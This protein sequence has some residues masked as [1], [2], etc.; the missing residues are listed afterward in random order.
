VSKDQQPLTLMFSN[1]V[2]T[3]VRPITYTVDIA[4][5]SGFSNKVF[6]RSGITPGASGTT[7]VALPDA[8][9]SDR[10][11]YWRSQAQDGANSSDYSAT[12]T[13]AI[14]TPIVIN[15]PVLV[16]PTGNV[17]VD[18]Q[19]PTFLFNDATRSGPVGAIAYTIEV[20]DSDS[21]AN[22]VAV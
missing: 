16:S 9:A 4:T 5:D 2:T 18:T 22:R 19:A 10:S 11:Y 13:F 21:F 17:T 15:A 8:L 12:S 6:T 1:S 14:Y 7:S 20:S 3:G